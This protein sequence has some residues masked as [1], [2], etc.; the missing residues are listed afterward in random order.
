MGTQKDHRATTKEPR[1][2]RS[3]G[4]YEDPYQQANGNTNSDPARDQAS[5]G[6]GDTSSPTVTITGRCWS[7]CYHD[8]DARKLLAVTQAGSQSAI[9]ARLIGLATPAW[10]L[11]SAEVPRMDEAELRPIASDRSGFVGLGPIG[12]GGDG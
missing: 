10:R 4:R 6:D 1:G 3:S 9:L 12:V 11:G 8:D 2:R 5:P 7:S